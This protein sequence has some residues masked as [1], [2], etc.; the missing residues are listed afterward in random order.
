MVCPD[1]LLHGGLRAQQLRPRRS[2]SRRCRPRSSQKAK[3]LGVH[4]AV[5]GAAGRTARR[6]PSSAPARPASAPRP[7]WPSWATRSTSSK[8]KHAR[9]HVQPDPRAPP[10]P[11]RCSTA[12][13]TSLL[14]ARATSTCTP[15]RTVRRARALLEQGYDAVLVATGLREPIRLG[16]ENEEQAVDGIDLPLPTPA[17]PML[18]GRR[19]AV[20][21]GGAIAVDC[22]VTAQR[23]G[24]ARVE[25]FALR[26][27]RRDAAHRQGATGP[28]RARHRRHRPHARAREILAEGGRSSGARSH[29]A[30]ALRRGQ[31]VPARRTIARRR[32][33]GAARAATSTRSS[34]PSAP[35]RRSRRTASPAVF[36]AG[37]CDE[38]PH[39]R[40]RGRRPPART[41]RCEV[42]A[43]LRKQPR[44]EARRGPAQE[45]SPRRRATPHVPG[46]ARDATS[47]A[48]RIRS[49]FLLSAAPPTD[50][51]E[52][53]KKA[54][55]A[56][57]AG[58]VMKTAF[59]GVPIHIPAEYMFAFDAARPTPT[60]TTSPATRWTASAARSSGWCR[61]SPTA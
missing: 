8:R 39:H 28:A 10:G 47:S 48:A 41:P 35:R 9:R 34:S 50:G 30:V 21:G 33:D 14:A 20:I 46:A 40:G 58:G 1:T 59:D 56:G 24:A 36:Y 42:D 45:P 38:R 4:A 17:A 23:A 19:V 22:A 16:I 43:L 26:E 6:S 51:Y 13:S 18:D 11:R 2:T 25:L 15:S 54:Y 44:A 5:R 37:D 3:A 55:E 52:Q 60:A 49:P 29:Q 27:A 57:W 12:T 7:C 32:R 61:S 31:T 53:M